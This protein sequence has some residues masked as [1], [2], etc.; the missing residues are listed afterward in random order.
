MNPKRNENLTVPSELPNE[1]TKPSADCLTKLGR[2]IDV[3]LITCR[4]PSMST[5]E[6]KV[7]PLL[8]AEVLQ[9]ARVPEWH[10]GELFRLALAEHTV[11]VP[12]MPGNVVAA[13]RKHGK[14][15]ESERVA[16]LTA[17]DFGLELN[18]VRSITELDGK[19]VISK[20]A[21]IDEQAAVHRWNEKLREDFLRTVAEHQDAAIIRSFE[22]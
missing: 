2:L 12:L 19:V 3:S 8:W 17:E 5:N 6:A 21:A 14:R 16:Q 4:L 22:W 15:L 20:A 7:M 9:A 18:L 1:M 10:W 11:S 13:W